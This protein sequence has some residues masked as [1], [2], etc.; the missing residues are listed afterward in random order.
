MCKILQHQDKVEK[1]L[2][3][4][5]RC[6]TMLKILLRAN[7]EIRLRVSCEPAVRAFP[8]RCKWPFLFL[9]VDWIMINVAPGK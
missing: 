7:L 5:L 2:T 8:H 3:L 4:D 9:I 6:G 1:K